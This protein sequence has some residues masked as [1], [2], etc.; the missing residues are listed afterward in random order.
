MNAETIKRGDHVTTPD[1]PG[2]VLMPTTPG[3]DR[4]TVLVADHAC[5]PFQR[6]Y[7]PAQLEPRP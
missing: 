6:D 4:V 7:Y 3:W 5:L 2:V 1:G